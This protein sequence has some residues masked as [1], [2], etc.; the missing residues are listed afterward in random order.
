MV[1]GHR[2]ILFLTGSLVLLLGAVPLI[3]TSIPAAAAWKETLP[4]TGSIIYN[5]ALILIGTF[6]IAHS[7]RKPEGKFKEILKALGK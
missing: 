7:L 5:I 3:V 4:P 6:A 1:L 2:S